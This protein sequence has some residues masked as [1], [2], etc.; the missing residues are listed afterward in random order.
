M[1]ELSSHVEIAVDN[2]TFLSYV[3]ADVVTTKP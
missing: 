2:Q 1:F 3:E